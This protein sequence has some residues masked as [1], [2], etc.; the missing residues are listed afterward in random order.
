MGV[1]IY[2]EDKINYHTV[3]Q[4][5]LDNRELQIKRIDNSYV[6]VLNVPGATSE[7]YYWKSDPDGNMTLHVK[8]YEEFPVRRYET[9]RGFLTNGGKDFCDIF[10]RIK[11]NTYYIYHNEPITRLF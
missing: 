1:E 2:T 4:T 6:V 10:S 3:L 5:G 7:M 8:V 11:D 9:L